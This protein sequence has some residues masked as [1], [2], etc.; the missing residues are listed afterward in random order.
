MHNKEGALATTG[1]YNEVHNRATSV[2]DEVRRQIAKKR[3]EAEAHC[4]IP[5]QDEEQGRRTSVDGSVQ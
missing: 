1:A 2:A 5:Q 4:I 3:Q